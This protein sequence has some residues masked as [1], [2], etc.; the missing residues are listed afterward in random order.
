MKKAADDI[1]Q[2]GLPATGR[3]HQ[4]DELALPHLEI[5]ALQHVDLLA[6]PLAGKTHPQI[7]DQHRR[8]CL[9]RRRIVQN[10]IHLLA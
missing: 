2:G 5:D 10:V 4:A 3:T 7:A 6:G 9:L 1:E 8:K